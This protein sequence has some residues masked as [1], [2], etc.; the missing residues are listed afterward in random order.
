MSFF[1]RPGCY[2]SFLFHLASSSCSVHSLFVPFNHLLFPHRSVSNA[3]WC[4]FDC[5]KC[6]EPANTRNDDSDDLSGCFFRCDWLS[7]RCQTSFPL[8]HLNTKHPFNYYFTL[9][10]P[11]CAFPFS[12]YPISPPPPFH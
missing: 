7:V 2:V 6:A 4:C 5:F 9:S 1:S 10:P 11:D 8:G 3:R 12:T